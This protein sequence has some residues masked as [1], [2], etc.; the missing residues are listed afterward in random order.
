MDDV[1][2]ILTLIGGALAVRLSTSLGCRVY[3]HH[4][5]PECRALPT[6]AARKEL[7]ES[8]ERHVASQRSL[9]WIVKLF[10]FTV[11]VALL[12]FVPPLT[13][14]IIAIIANLGFRFGKWFLL[15]ED[16]QNTARRRLVELGFPLCV[17]CG[18]DLRAATCEIC[19]E[20][21]NGPYPGVIKPSK[22]PATAAM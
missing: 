20:C 17:Y 22:K 5:V 2:V 14:V 10:C 9:G 21:G 1:W 3:L 15:R 4:V 19:P 11:L 13:V 6:K 12:K 7:Y 18:Y 16:V 8:I